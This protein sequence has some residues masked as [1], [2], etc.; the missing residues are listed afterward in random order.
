MP[1]NFVHYS[2]YLSNA[3]TL[4]KQCSIT[5]NK[6]AKNETVQKCYTPLV[7]LC[8]GPN[9]A[10]GGA[11]INSIPDILNQYDNKKRYKKEV[12]IE[13]CKTYYETSCTNRYVEKSPGKFVADST[14]EKIPFELCGRGN[15]SI[16]LKL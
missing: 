14:C 1:S 7:K 12:G 4:L 8:D 13:Q 3:I 16:L 9:T 10:K 15:F 2:A 11:S 6:Q 5:F